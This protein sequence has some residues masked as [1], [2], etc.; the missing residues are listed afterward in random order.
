MKEFHPLGVATDR[1]GKRTHYFLSHTTPGLKKSITT[2]PTIVLTE[3]QFRQ[4]VHDGHVQIFQDFG[5]GPVVAHTE[6]EAKLFKKASRNKLS[7]ENDTELYWKGENTMRNDVITVPG[8]VSISIVCA[9]VMSAVRLT[10]LTGALYSQ[11]IPKSVRE[12]LN[13]NS[14]MCNAVAGDMFVMSWTKDQL[15]TCITT[16]QKAGA[17][18][19]LNYSSM[20]NLDNQVYEAKLLGFRP[21]TPA[22][23]A[24]TTAFLDEITPVLPNAIEGGDGGATRKVSKMNLE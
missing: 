14:V 2:E 4:Y 17:L 6:E 1:T 19:T 3:E 5:H 11:S 8:A 10:N 18:V 23:L 22:E 13:K 12:F 9:R 15:E 20:R 24:D 16:L 7:V 21:V